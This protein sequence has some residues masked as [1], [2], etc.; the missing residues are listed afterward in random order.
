[1]KKFSISS[2]VLF[3]FCWLFI[4]ANPGSIESESAA[5]HS[6]NPIIGHLQ[7]REMSITIE[8]GRDGP[9]Y[10]IRSDKGEVLATELS[11]SKLYSKFPRLKDW[12]KRGF[13][14]E[15][16]SLGP[17]SQGNWKRIDSDY[18]KKN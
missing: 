18:S 11:E 15:D 1:M 8:I 14:R 3:I 2:T 17:D 5:T 9:V 13:A 10:T 6:T 16:A 7:G 12:F 4:L